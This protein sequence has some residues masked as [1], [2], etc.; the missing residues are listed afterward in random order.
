M[1]VAKEE[2]ELKINVELECTPESSTNVYHKKYTFSN[3]PLFL[4][5]IFFIGSCYYIGN[6]RLNI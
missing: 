4:E 3:R 5:N 1:Y 2:I 6:N